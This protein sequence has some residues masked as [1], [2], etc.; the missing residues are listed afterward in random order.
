MRYIF[1]LCVLYL[2]KTGL[3]Y[4]R[5]P[6]LLCVLHP[7]P[8]SLGAWRGRYTDNS[9]GQPWRCSHDRYKHFDTR[10]WTG[11]HYRCSLVVLDKISFDRLICSFTHVMRV[12]KRFEMSRNFSCEQRSRVSVSVSQWDRVTP[13]GKAT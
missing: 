7:W 13:W 12:W 5:L 1:K 9:I 6:D 11:S 8:V 2:N 3:Q 4:Y 10:K